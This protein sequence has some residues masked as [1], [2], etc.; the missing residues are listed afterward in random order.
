MA[1][2]LV[3]SVVKLH[4][5]TTCLFLVTCWGLA[6]SAYY[7]GDPILCVSRYD[8]S[9]IE[10]DLEEMCITY[11][12]NT[13]SL[14][15]TKYFPLHYK[16]MHWIFLMLALI[17]KL[18]G[19][20]QKYIMFEPFLEDTLESIARLPVD[21]DL[22]AAQLKLSLGYWLH[23]Y[24]R[25][26]DHLARKIY[27]L[28]ISMFSNCLGFF[29]MNLSLQG[30]YYAKLVTYW[31]FNRD[32]RTFRD[33]LSSVFPPFTDCELTPK[34]Q[35]WLGRTERA[36][37]HL[38]LMEAYEKTVLIFFVWQMILLIITCVEIVRLICCDR[39]MSLRLRMLCPGTYMKSPLIQKYANVKSGEIYALSL[40]RNLLTKPQLRCLLYAIARDYFHEH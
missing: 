29:V 26:G 38:P 10:D 20:F 15:S 9:V 4:S 35:L 3:S 1:D 34:M 7:F 18:P 36:G 5:S 31:P 17:Y 30:H 12:F 2:A 37:C 40:F 39:I 21:F 19:F 23:N 13:S 16:W 22:Q 28:F 11:S 27:L 14:Q 25:H 24:G 32:Y 8:G 33:P 6:T